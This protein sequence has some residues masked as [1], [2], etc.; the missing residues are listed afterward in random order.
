MRP[1]RSLL[2][3]VTAAALVGPGVVLSAEAAPP[4]PS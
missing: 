3:V 4:L 1:L 2:A